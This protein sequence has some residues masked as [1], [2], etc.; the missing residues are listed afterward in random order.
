[1]STLRT[2]EAPV[3][4]GDQKL[5]IS[6]RGAVGAPKQQDGVR[7]GEIPPFSP[8]GVNYTPGH[9]VKAALMRI[10]LCFWL[11]QINGFRLWLVIAALG[12]LALIV[13][14]TSHGL[15]HLK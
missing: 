9:R 14:L 6:A 3:I 15:G 4:V 13:I 7:H 2:Y 5:K 1:V 10:P 8:S 11:M 12:V